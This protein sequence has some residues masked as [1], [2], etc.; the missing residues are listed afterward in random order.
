MVVVK[1]VVKFLEVDKFSM[2]MISPY[3]G[4]ALTTFSW[5]FFVK[6]G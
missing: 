5:I 2:S 3:F 1:N 4:T 6:K